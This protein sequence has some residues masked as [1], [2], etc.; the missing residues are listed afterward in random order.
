MTIL[1]HSSERH[2]LPLDLPRKI[3]DCR[4]RESSSL[5]SVTLLGRFSGA[6][7]EHEGDISP[8]R[9]TDGRTDYLDR[10]NGGG[11]DGRDRESDLNCPPDGPP[12]QIDGRSIDGGSVIVVRPPVVV[13]NAVSSGS[14]TMTDLNN[15]KSFHGRG[16]ELLVSHQRRR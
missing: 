3:C 16:I 13:A 11:R 9:P 6:F 14:L 5:R 15:M 8:L 4:R 12:A 1:S 7:S 2:T 10:C